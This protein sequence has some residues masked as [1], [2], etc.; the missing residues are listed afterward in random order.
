[1][2]VTFAESRAHADRTLAN[3][4]TPYVRH[5]E[6]HLLLRDTDGAVFRGASSHVRYP[7][8]NKGTKGLTSESVLWYMSNFGVMHPVL[9]SNSTLDRTDLAVEDGPPRQ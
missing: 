5:V 4:H 6:A 7:P 9:P 8:Q 3:Y 2:V 1:V